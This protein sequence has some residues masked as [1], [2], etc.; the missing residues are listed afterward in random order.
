MGSVLLHVKPITEEITGKSVSL[1]LI[2]SLFR[3]VKE[4]PPNSS[5]AAVWSPESDLIL[6]DFQK[7]ESSA[8]DVGF[9]SDVIW[10][11]VS[12]TQML[13][14]LVKLYLL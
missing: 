1:L 4:A 9:S 2:E 8:Q 12:C 10:F 13:F 3:A 6:F 14:C 7:C 5:A 11:F